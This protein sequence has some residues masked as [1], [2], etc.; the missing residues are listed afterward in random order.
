[1]H[2]AL[3]VFLRMRIN[4]TDTREKGWFFSLSLSHAHTHTHTHTHIHTYTLYSSAAPTQIVK[5]L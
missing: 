4:N 5:W 3:V 2:T 1:M